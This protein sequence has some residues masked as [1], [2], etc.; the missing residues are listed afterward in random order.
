MVLDSC[1]V[2]PD[3]PIFV[4]YYVSVSEEQKPLG[5]YTKYKPV[6]LG[7]DGK[8]K[9]FKNEPDRFHWES[10]VEFASYL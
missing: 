8:E 3:V 4:L 9:I 7:V 2:C 6:P 1:W 5:T 10:V